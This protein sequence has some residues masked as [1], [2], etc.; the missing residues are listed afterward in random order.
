MPW[1]TCNKMDSKTAFISD[2]L[3]ADLCIAELC[4]R[5]SISRTCG[6]KWIKRFK[7]NGFEGLLDHSR[8]PHNSP[9]Q[10]CVDIEQA[11]VKVRLEFPDWGGRK[12]RRVLKNRGYTDLPAPSTIT[13]ILRRHDLLGLGTREG[14]SNVQRFERDAPND[15]WQM[16]FKGWFELDNRRQCHPL[17]ALDDH[18]RFNLILE[19]CA[20]ES[21]EEIQPIL[22]R[23]FQRYGMPLQILV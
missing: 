5:H 10:S 22:A 4:R 12:I 15:L 17:T 8:R 20:K 1:T 19:A 6:Y 11:C 14:S 3:R 18:S 9:G 23:T 7:E 16:D 2:Y 13:N 21:M